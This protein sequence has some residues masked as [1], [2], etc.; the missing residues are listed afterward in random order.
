MSN[1][2][3]Q[4]LTITSFYSAQVDNQRGGGQ[5]GYAGV[6]GVAADKLLLRLCK[7]N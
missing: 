4:T 3:Y 2:V 6:I 1:T 5:D 7:I